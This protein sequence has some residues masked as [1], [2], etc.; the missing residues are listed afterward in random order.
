MPTPIAIAVVEHD[1]HFLIGQRPPDVPLPGYWEFPGGKVEPG[2]TPSETAKR[3]CF[4]EAGLMVTIGPSYPEVVHQY[5][6]DRLKLYFFACQPTDATMVP[7]PPFR[8]VERHDLAQYRFPPANSGL[9]TYLLG[10]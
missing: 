1:N 9:L 2:E 8:W 7:K 10:S 4:E 6:H 3:E 5:D